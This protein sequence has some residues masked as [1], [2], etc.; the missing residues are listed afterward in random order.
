M[1]YCGI[2]IK[3]RKHKQHVA[4]PLSFYDKHPT[5][6]DF[7]VAIFTL[8]GFYVKPPKKLEEKD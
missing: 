3:L 4:A 5:I 7:D 1:L 8:D 6:F 2:L